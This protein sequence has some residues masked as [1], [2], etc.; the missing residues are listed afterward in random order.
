MQKYLTAIYLEFAHSCACF[1]SFHLRLFYYFFFFS[2]R[3]IACMENCYLCRPSWARELRAHTNAYITITQE[4]QLSTWRRSAMQ[5]TKLNKKRRQENAYGTRIQ[6]QL[7]IQIHRARDRHRIR[8][9]AE[10]SQ[11]QSYR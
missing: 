1:V 2:F 11:S 3:F 5:T 9:G 7:E 4:S 10:Q 6:R 8:D